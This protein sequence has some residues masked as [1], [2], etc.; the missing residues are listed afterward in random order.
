MQDRLLTL[1]LLHRRKQTAGHQRVIDPWLHSP[2]TP[3]RAAC[4]TAP[5]AAGLGICWAYPGPRDGGV[6]CS[7]GIVG[8]L[9]EEFV[10]SDLRDEILALRETEVRKLAAE[11][12]AEGE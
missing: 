1:K 7:G 10:R 8:F 3:R 2:I 9:V 4:Q 5:T 6:T 12:G 11:Y